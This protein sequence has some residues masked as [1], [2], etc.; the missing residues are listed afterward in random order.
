MENPQVRKFVPTASQGT[1]L[2]TGQEIGNSDQ[3]IKGAKG[4]NKMVSKVKSL[5]AAT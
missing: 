4:T 2:G 5:R 3:W 1:L